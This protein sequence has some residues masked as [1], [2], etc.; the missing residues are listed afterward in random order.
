MKQQWLQLQ[1]VIMT[2]SY[3]LL[4]W[5][6]KSS[7]WSTLSNSDAEIYTPY[8]VAAGMLLHMNGK[9]TMSISRCKSRYEADLSV[10]VVSFISSSM[11]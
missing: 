6:D 1:Y 4:M 2:K 11:G 10:Y 3:F 9:F 7:L 5:S 8:A